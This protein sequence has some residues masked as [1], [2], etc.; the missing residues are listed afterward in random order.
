MPD[1]AFAR[2]VPD[3]TSEEVA[4]FFTSLIEAAKVKEVVLHTN[5]A[6]RFRG[7]AT[8]V[9]DSSL[10]AAAVLETTGGEATLRGRSLQLSLSSKEASKEPRPTREP[11]QE[12][13]QEPAKSTKWPTHPTT[14]FVKG[15]GADASEGSL[16]ADFA[17][18][19][20]VVRARILVDKKTGTSKGEGLVQF[21]E[22]E[23]VVKALKRA[24]VETSRFPAVTPESSR[25]S[26]KKQQANPYL[27]AGRGKAKSKNKNDFL[28]SKMSAR[29]AATI[30]ATTS[31]KE[32]DQDHK[33]PAP[34]KSF[35]FIPRVLRK[36]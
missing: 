21:Q 13:A 18:C 29:Q 19:G 15:L 17:D 33:N 5:K 2:W 31:A 32:S 34:K 24:N 20:R 10:A 23:S 22:V 3:V 28:S 9:L 6:G 11:A 25:S 35:S 1:L 36:P 14:I 12:P 27:E 16:A 7:M 30:S 8:A 4:N 26:K